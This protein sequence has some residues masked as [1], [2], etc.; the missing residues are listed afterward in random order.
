MRK[1]THYSTPN[2]RDHPGRNP[3]WNAG[4]RRYSDRSRW[5]PHVGAKQI[6]KEL[7]KRD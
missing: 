1:P 3:R 2:F 4:G 7:A 6:A 5:K